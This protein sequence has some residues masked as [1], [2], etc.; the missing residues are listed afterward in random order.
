VVMAPRMKTE[1]NLSDNRGLILEFY[2]PQHLRQYS[3]EVVSKNSITSVH[4][5]LSLANLKIN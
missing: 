4:F 1:T 2:Q 3:E 5:Y